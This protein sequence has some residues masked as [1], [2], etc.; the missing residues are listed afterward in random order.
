MLFTTPE[1]FIFLTVILICVEFLRKR[2]WQHL[3]LLA[4]SYYFYWYSGAIHVLLMAFVTVATYYCGAKIFATKNKEEKKVWLVIGVIIPLAILGF[5][6]YMGFGISSI[7]SL[8]GAAGVV[9][10]L[11]LLEVLLPIGISFFT[12][13]ALSYVF[14]IYLSRLEPIAEFHKYLLFIAFFPA[15]V[16][17]PIV[18]ASEFLP[19]LKDEVVI[20]GKNLQIG[21]TPS[22]SG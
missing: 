8:L 16:A 5:F 7:N 19:Q 3:L 4:A 11:P 14:D 12:F 13:Q 20:T 9:I 22:A 21:I 18:R 17:G 1:Y 15:L 2:L 10:S 6:K